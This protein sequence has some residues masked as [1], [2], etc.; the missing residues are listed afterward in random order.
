MTNEVDVGT[1]PSI[2][3]GNSDDD[4]RQKPPV[5]PFITTSD[6]VNQLNKQLALL[7]APSEPSDGV[8]RG[9][10]WSDGSV[11]G[12]SSNN[13]NSIISLENLRQQPRF[14]LQKRLPDGSAVPATADEISAADFKTKLEQAAKFVS[15]LATSRDRQY[16]AEQQRRLGNSYFA[17]GDY[18]SA[19]DVYLTCL[20]VKEN[21]PDFVNLTLVPG[22]YRITVDPER[23]N[24]TLWLSCML[25]CRLLDYM[26]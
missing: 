11:H 5:S 9:G 13:N 8:G 19:M 25:S 1:A 10:S 23:E 4:D 22:E 21:T 24:Q 15:Q 7:T 26:R 18:K 6:I 3:T 16:W 2:D 14:E 12:S 20:L 17:S